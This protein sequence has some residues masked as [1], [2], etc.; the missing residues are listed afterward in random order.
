MIK[1]KPTTYSSA[2]FRSRL[3]AK[4]AAF[5]DLCGWRWEYEPLDLDGWVPDFG[6]VGAKGLILCE[7]KPI[8][9]TKNRET[10]SILTKRKD[11]D[12][13]KF[14]SKNREILVLGAYPFFM[15]SV[16]SYCI[17]YLG[18]LSE[19]NE[20]DLSEAV[21]FACFSRLS[22][23]IDFRSE[24]M[25]YH[26]RI[27]GKQNGGHTTEVDIS[28]IDALWRKASSFVQWNPNG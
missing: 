3:E 24:N 20:N 8:E 25:S 11:L 26:E 6:I 4:W 5:F 23:H 16:Y 28:E 1:A 27:S 17:S 10:N 14:A 2:H 15:E 21:D 9:W 18:F 19:I 13:I 7:V 22:S 12:K